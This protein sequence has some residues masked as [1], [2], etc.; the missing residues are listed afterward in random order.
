MAQLF[1]DAARAYLS[2]GINDTDTAISIT[3]GGA[4]FP[5]ANGTDWFKAV[6]QDASGIEIVYVT[7]HTSASTSFTVTRGQEG[8]TARSFAA[9]SVFGL[10]VT[11]ADTAAFAGKLGDA[12][13]D[14]KT[15]GRK[16]AAWAE[17]VSGATYRIGDVQIAPTAPAT[18]A[19]LLCDG[20]TYLQSSYTD[21]YA[22]IGLIANSPG[23]VSS[24][25]SRTMPSS[26]NWAAMAYG[27]G[28]FVATTSNGTNV[29]ASSTDGATWT[30]RT[31]PTNQRWNG[32]AYGNGVFVAVG[33]SLS[34]TATNVVATSPDGVTWTNRTISASST[35]QSVAYGNGTFV[36]ISR[37]TGT[38]ASTSP[39]GITWTARTLPT[40]AGW[41]AITF[42]NGIFVAVASGGTAA[43]IS[44]DGISWTAVTLPVSGNWR[45]IAYGNGNFVTLGLSSAVALTSPDGI[46]WTSRTLPS[47]SNWSA[48]AFG[49]GAFMA[50]T[51]TSGNTCAVSSDGIVWTTRTLPATGT[52]YGVAYGNKVFVTAAL[53]STS[54]ASAYA[55]ISYNPST[56]F[57]VPRAI[58]E[59]INSWV[60]A[61]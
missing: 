50:V 26:A 22:A 61:L 28:V 5:V 42:G 6:L 12:P 7:A 53:A 44:P 58:S 14:G 18:G 45:A 36:A 54:A 55:G 19:W 27:N 16:D 15:Y 38:T 43:A 35:W 1:A 9:G 21:L 31:F 4:L 48:V 51:Q 29:A 11:A 30:A 60:K 32:V 39:D 20:S 34:G 10:R 56:Q 24:F 52:Y 8:T 23:Q 59:E 46:T 47:S 37:A 57:A 49:G 25:T 33:D 40:S 17:V 3:A 2:A 41:W 13:S